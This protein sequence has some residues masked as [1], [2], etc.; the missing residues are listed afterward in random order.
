MDVNVR[1]I[2]ESD[3]AAFLALCRQLDQETTYMMYEPDERRTTVDEQ[4]KAIRSTLESGGAI[5]VAEVDGRLAGYVAASGGEFRR[6]RHSRYVVAGVLQ[7]FA[8]R[9]IGTRLFVEMESWAKE[10]GLH[11]LEL[12]VQTR[13]VAGVRLYQKIGFEIEGTLRHTLQIDGEY[14]DEYAMA[15]LLV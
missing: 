14:V 5:L 10:Q 4:G 7:D 3:A 2:A 13:N 8:G 1:T 12:T 11:R 9:G 15:K 6:N